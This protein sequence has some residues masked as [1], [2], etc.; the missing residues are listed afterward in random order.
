M[1]N[2]RIVPLHFIDRLGELNWTEIELGHSE[3][4]LNSQSVIDIAIRRVVHGSN[5]INEIELAGL[6]TNEQVY[7]A[8]ILSKLT[9]SEVNNSSLAPRMAW[10]RI[11]M[12]WLYEN[13]N[14]IGDPFGVIEQMYADFGYPVEIRHLVRYNETTRALGSKI[15]A[16]QQMEDDW[17]EYVRGISLGPKLGS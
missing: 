7:V 4:W 6:L 16:R 15:A 10:F 14:T 8:E 2:S 13:K 11:L 9:A 17:A 12:A 3:G 5:N 1:H